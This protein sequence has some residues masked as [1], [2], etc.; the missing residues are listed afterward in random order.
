MKNASGLDTVGK[1]IAI[2]IVFIVCYLL[3][4]LPHPVGEAIIFSILAVNI[5]ELSIGLA[6]VLEIVKKKR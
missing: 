2:V 3:L 6:K 5:A 4:Q 1:I